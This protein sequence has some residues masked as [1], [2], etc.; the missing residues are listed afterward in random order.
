MT[1]I[2]Y[3]SPEILRSFAQ[4]NKLNFSLMSDQNVE[5]F[6]SLDVLN[7]KYKPGDKHYGIPYPGVIVLDSNRVIKH[8]Y[9]FEGYKKRVKFG[10]LLEQ[11]K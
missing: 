10:K 8:K 9:F 11:L 7:A 5:S 6:K 4:E 1:A 2:S 3:V